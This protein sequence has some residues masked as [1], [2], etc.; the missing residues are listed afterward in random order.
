MS[1]TFGKTEC[2]ALVCTCT[3]VLL[4][5]TA[6][7]IETHPGWL[8]TE[9]LSRSYS[10]SLSTSWEIFPGW[11]ISSLFNRKLLSPTLLGCKEEVLKGLNHTFCCQ[12]V[13]WISSICSFLFYEFGYNSLP[14]PSCPGCA[15]SNFLSHFNST[16]PYVIHHCNA[17]LYECFFL[18]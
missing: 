6:A 17:S 12:L 5:P 14:I 9:H 16:Y 7:E 4:L 8:P 3:F 18:K 1:P 2:F 10:S 13:F 11:I 15:V